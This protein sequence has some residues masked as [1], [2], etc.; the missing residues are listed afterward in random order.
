MR[1]LHNYLGL[2]L[3]L[4]LWL[5]AVSGLV[6]NHSSWGAAQFWKQR[7]ETSTIRPI[8]VPRA[9]DDIGLATDL[10]RQLAI[11]GEVMETKR[12]PDGARFEFQVVKPGRVAR[13]DVRLDSARAVVTNIELNAWGVVDALHKFTGTRMDDP[14]PT[15]DW[16]LT[17]LWSLSMDALAIGLIVLVASGVYLW[18]R[19]AGA[20]RRAGLVALTAGVV[21][22]AFFVYGLAAMRAMSNR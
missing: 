22:C 17:K 14:A 18:Y 1:K 8:D 13:V 21:S 20:R 3:L 6:L 19:G 11:V 5:F 12:S 2:S 16:L 9:R 7:N 10:M 4:F 15:R